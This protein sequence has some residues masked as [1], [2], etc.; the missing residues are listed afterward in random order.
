MQILY[1]AMADFYHQYNSLVLSSFALQYAIEVSVCLHLSASLR[2]PIRATQNRPTVQTSPLDLPIWFSKVHT[3]AMGVLTVV[4]VEIAP[5]GLLPSFTDGQLVM[6]CY[7]VSGEID[8]LRSCF[9]TDRIP[10]DGSVSPCS[11]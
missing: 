11:K 7:A 3:A 1:R 8:R 4:K 5:R 10:F 6:L 9:E 2:Y